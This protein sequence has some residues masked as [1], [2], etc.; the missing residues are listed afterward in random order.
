MIAKLA[1]GSCPTVATNVYKAISKTTIESI[2]VA[3]P[4]GAS[5]TVTVQI[6]NVGLFSVSMPS[7]GGV[8]FEGPQVLEPGQSISLVSSS[9]SCS[10]NIT[11]TF[12]VT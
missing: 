9:A 5:Q 6:N 10:Y 11:G 1:D 4:T 7:L 12:P 8:S 3:N 2:D